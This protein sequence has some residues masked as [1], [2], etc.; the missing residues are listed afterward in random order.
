MTELEKIK[1]RI[2]RG[3]LIIL[4]SFLNLFMLRSAALLSP[5]IL[6]WI[7][8]DQWNGFN[9]LS[10]FLVILLPI[11][12]AW[13][14]YFILTTGSVLLRG[15]LLIINLIYRRACKVNLDQLQ[16]VSERF[17]KRFLFSFG[18][19]ITRIN[20]VGNNG[21]PTFIL[22]MEGRSILSIPGPSVTEIIA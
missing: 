15:N 13:S 22:I 21:K 2:E 18:T 4:T 11:L 14:L 12:T 6:G 17:I 1:G 9:G 5:L 8:Y 7:I 16:G 20:Y 19:R 10:I 3:E